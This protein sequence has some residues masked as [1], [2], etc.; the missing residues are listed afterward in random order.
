MQG[1]EQE[2]GRGRGDE[3]WRL[4]VRRLED[5]WFTYQLVLLYEE[6][7]QLSEVDFGSGAPLDNRRDIESLC[8]ASAVL[9]E[10]VAP[11]GCHVCNVRGC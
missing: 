5:A 8:E 1:Y 2:F 11:N 3:S 9:L 7:N 6:H 10:K 4:N